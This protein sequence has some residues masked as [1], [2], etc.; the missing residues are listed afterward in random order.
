MRKLILLFIFCLFGCNSIELKSTM[1]NDNEDYQVSLVAVGDNL[2][3]NSI[4]NS[5]Y[6][7]GT[8]DFNPIY[9][10][11]KPYIKSHDIAF[12]NQETILGGSTLGLSS[13]P[14]F[15]SPFEIGDALIDCGFNLISLANNHSLDRREEAI[16]NSLGYWSKQ[17][18]IYSGTETSEEKKIKIFVKNNIKFA[19]VAYTYGTNGIPIPNGKDYLVNLYSPEIAK[20]DVESIKDKVD[21]II[22]SMHWGNEY[23]HNPSPLQTEQA[24]YLSSLGVDLIMGHHPHVIQPIRVIE[25]EKQKTIVVYSLGNFLSDQIG[26]ECLIGM[27]FSI[28]ITKSIK[29]EIVDIEINNPKAKLLYRYK[30]PDD[31]TFSIYF[32]EQLDDSLLF[33]Y[34]KYFNE[35]KEIIVSQN[36]TIKVL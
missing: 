27:A 11:I 9:Q 24:E 25:T 36:S 1:V 5:S 32:F 3:H 10:E 13:Y 8:Y 14:R 21:V 26:I 33:N 4:Y 18:V 35:T 23:K 29:D 6:Q 16:E 2:I 17:N 19:F 30:D 31:K 7:D 15:N 20:S 12:V 22:V 34:E 28:E